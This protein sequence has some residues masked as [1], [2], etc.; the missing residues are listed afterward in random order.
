MAR[1]RYIAIYK[2]VNTV[3]SHVDD[4]YSPAF[5][6]LELASA[7][8]LDGVSRLAAARYSIPWLSH[9]QKDGARAMVIAKP[10]RGNADKAYC[11]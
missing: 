6:T 2:L 11:S 10:K 9:G 5:S 1:C 8:P 3:Y 4:S 7:T